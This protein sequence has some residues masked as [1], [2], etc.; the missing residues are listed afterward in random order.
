MKIVVT[1]YGEGL[2]AKFDRSFGRARWFVCVDTDTGA[3]EARS[4]VQNIDA[5]QGA[6]IQAA[7]NVSEMGAGAIL[8]GN[9]GPNAYRTMKAAGIEV[10]VVGKEC[11]TVEDALAAWKAGKAEVISEPT[12][13]GHWV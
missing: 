8:T 12:V 4:N 6:G 11:E 13:E 9:V 1:S 10:F 2:S 3:V 5:P 7:K